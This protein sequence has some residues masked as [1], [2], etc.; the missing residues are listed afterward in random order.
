LTSTNDTSVRESEI[1][2]PTI[3]SML[4][5]KRS[6]KANYLQ[7][8]ISLYLFSAGCPSKTVEVFK[9]IGLAVARPT[10]MRSLTTL[11]ASASKEVQRLALKRP[12]L[13]VYDNINRADKKVHQRLDNKDEFHNGTT[14]T[15]VIKETAMEP[16]LQCNTSR[17]L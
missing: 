16:A 4:L 15:V 8:M 14:A 11:A 10:L 6:Q 1:L 12:F 2:V 7:K 17:H 3:A 13:V 5:I 9:E